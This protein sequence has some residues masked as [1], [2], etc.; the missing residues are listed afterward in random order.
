MGRW[1][2]TS[3]AVGVLT[4][5]GCTRP[6]PAPP[7]PATPPPG[8]CV[9]G[10]LK[11]LAASIPGCAGVPAGVLDAA[12][13][14]EVRLG[15]RVSVRGVLV[16]GAG[17][18]TMKACTFV[19]RDGGPD[20][21]HCCNSCRA[22]WL[23]AGLDEA[24]ADPAVLSTAPIFLRRA[25]EKRLLGAGAKDCV[26]SAM[27]ASPREEVIASGRLESGGTGNDLGSSGRGALMIDGVTLCATGRWAPPRATPDARSPVCR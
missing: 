3:G 22:S 10:P 11:D 7:P 8:S 5:V 21:P 4:L 16:L 12:R 18:C 19:H 2:R 27:A 9:P 23:L 20:S 6:P 26:M 17:E 24:S 14:R 13:L 1:L 25:G 15:S